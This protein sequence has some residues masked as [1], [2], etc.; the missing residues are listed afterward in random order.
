MS[1]ESPSI[2]S[3]YRTT[4]KDKTMDPAYRI[5]DVVFVHPTEPPAPDCNIL[6]RSSDGREQIR[7]LVRE[8][9]AHWHVRQWNPERD[10]MVLKRPE[11]KVSRI[12]G[13]FDGGAV[14]ELEAAAA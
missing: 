11:L 3:G 13:S 5:G 7:R 2:W 8:T 14:A 6:I 1:S 10:F 9:K 4:V 12:A